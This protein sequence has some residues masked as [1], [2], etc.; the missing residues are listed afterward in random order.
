M[1]VYLLLV[2]GLV[3]L[4]GGANILVLG[5]SSIA[6]KF[7]IPNLVIGLTVVSFGTSFPELIINIL[8]GVNGQSDLAIGNVVG[9]NTINILLVIGV[10]ALIRP[11]SVQSNT[12]KFEIPFSV[13]AMLIL[14]VL[15]NDVLF[16][17]ANHSV[18]SRSDGFMFLTFFLIFMY[19]TFVVSKHSK[20]DDGHH[21][22]E[23]AIWKSILFLLIGIIGLY[24]GG[25]LIV[26]NATVIALKLGL[27]EAVIGILVIA[28]GTSLPELATSAVAAY[29]GNADMAIGNIVGSNIFNVF[30]VL[31]ISASIHPIAFSISLNTDILFALFSSALLFLFIFTR[32]GRQIDRVEASVFL[33]LYGAYVVCL[34]W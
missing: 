20:N 1:L 27:S 16:D 33:V 6:K 26:D 8:A 17:A 24:F 32:K 28:L 25:G 7:N 31:G 19:Y 21:V 11:I 29:K 12:V 15:A 2:I 5:A 9:S 14:F 13:L 3:V 34:L 30:F 10:S 22:Q 18:L 4:I 23:K